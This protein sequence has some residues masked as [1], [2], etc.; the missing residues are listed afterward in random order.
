MIKVGR[1][2]LTLPLLANGISH[3]SINTK[4]ATTLPERIK[5]QMQDERVPWGPVGYVTYKRTYSRHLDEDDDNSPKEEYWQTISRCLQGLLDINGAL[6][7]RELECLAGYL[8]QL[9]CNFSG[10]QLWQLGTSTVQRIGGDSLQACWHVRVNEPIH[11]FT[12]NFEQL[13]LGGGVGFTILPE[14]VYSLPP[15]KHRIRVTRVDT[16]DCD[17]IIPDNREGWIEFLRKVLDGFFF[18]GKSITYNTRCIRP[19]GQRIK[20]FGGTASGPEE[21]VIGMNEIVK[22]LTRCHGRKIDPI[23]AMDIENI[24]AMIV[25]AGNVR[26]SAQIACGSGRDRDFLLAKYWDDGSTIIPRW[27]QQSNNTVTEH[28]LNNLLPEFWWPYEKVNEDGRATGECYGLFNKPLS[29]NYGRLIDGPKPGYNAGVCGPNPCGEI[30]LE[31]DE[32]CNLAEL[33]L[34]NLR[35]STEFHIAATLM[36]KCQKIVS[37]LPFLHP[38]TNEVISRNHRL[39]QGVTGVAAAHHL[40][41]PHI[42]DGVYKH[43]VEEDQEYSVTLNTDMSLAYTTVKPS[44]T[45]AKLPIGCTPGGNNAY[46]NPQLLRITFSSDSPMLPTLKKKGYRFEPKLNLDGSIDFNSIM[47]PFPIK[48]PAG[49]PVDGDHSAVQQLENVKFLQTWWSDNA[50][51]AT[52]QFRQEEVPAIKAW[53]FENYTDSLKS[54][55][56]SRHTG[57]GFVQPP[58]EPLTL[59]EYE[60]YAG[61][62]ESIDYFENDN[63]DSP[64]DGIECSGDKCGVK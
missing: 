43:I 27:R 5:R 53:L 55:A 49:T 37:V 6:T 21:L 58:N 24:L 19:R 13:M 57:H 48:Y 54:I 47:V 52:I 60:E 3:P 8:M 42:F 26:R 31:S 9:K 25:V 2:M 45:S 4:Y 64:I 23:D 56:F 63:D 32:A 44:G 15:V 16:F 59:E 18:T 29:A 17:F 7:L 10:R 14:D 22:I 40:R 38:R 12:F 28:D 1:T 20:S 61:S 46:A 41:K 34:T 50:V 35:D 33:Y 62:V 51:S 36:Y 30:P 39:G 11:P